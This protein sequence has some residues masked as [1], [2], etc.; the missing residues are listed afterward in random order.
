MSVNYLL[1]KDNHMIADATS[2]AIFQGTVFG[3]PH[4]QDEP[5]NSYK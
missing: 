2:D 3:F 1:M 4:L 5:G